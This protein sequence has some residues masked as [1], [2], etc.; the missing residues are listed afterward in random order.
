MRCQPLVVGTDDRSRY[1]MLSALLLSGAMMGVCAKG[2][3]AGPETIA[4]DRPDTVESSLTVGAR[5]LQLETSIAYEHDREEGIST[6]TWSMPTLLR[7]GVSEN[8]E[9][10][11]ET[12]GPLHER[13]DRAGGENNASGMGD[14]AI[15][16]KHHLETRDGSPWSRALLLHLDVPSGDGHWKGHKNRPS[17][18]YVAEREI[19]ERGSLG[20]MPG[21][22]YNTDDNR[23]YY[24]SGLLAVT[25]GYSFTDEWR[26]FLEIASLE[27]GAGHHADFQH[28]FDGGLAWTL[29]PDLQLDFVF[30]L[31]LSKAT[32][33]LLLGSGI[34]LRW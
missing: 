16:V 4:T 10:R 13:L 15:G 5:R 6:D 20:I 34:S 33:D 14:L 30:N 26:G 7:Y 1:K 17:A 23:E 9:L 31:G 25:S 12:D 32:S 11:V 19:G 2:Y 24:W 21:V 18:R 27:L 22:V 3:A 8:W 28:S 29:T